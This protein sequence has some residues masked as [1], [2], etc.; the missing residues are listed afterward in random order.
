MLHNMLYRRLNHF[1]DTLLDVDLTLFVDIVYIVAELCRVCLSRWCY[2]QLKPIAILEFIGR[3]HD[4]V[5]FFRDGLVFRPFEEILTSR[6]CLAVISD[7]WAQKQFYLC[8]LLDFIDF[9]WVYF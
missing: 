3:A 8:V 2:M 7:S 5:I 6:Q 9:K 1:L 4:C